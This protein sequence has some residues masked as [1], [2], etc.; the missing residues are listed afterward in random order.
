MDA[1]ELMVQL[2]VESHL[3]TV[4]KTPCRGESTF[5]CILLAPEW[6]TIFDHGHDIVEFKRFM[7]L[8]EA[9]YGCSQISAAAMAQ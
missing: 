1:E 3:L 6:A 4:S 2:L 9:W 5:Q 8:P 7:Y